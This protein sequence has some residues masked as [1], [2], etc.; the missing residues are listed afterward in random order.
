MALTAATKTD[1]YRFFAVAFNAAPGVT[2]MNQLAE[3]ANV[4]TVQQIVEVFTTKPEFT[5]TYPTFFTNS[6]FA[7]KLVNT[8]VGTSASDA[9]KAEAIADIEAALA[10][11]RPAA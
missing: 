1:L 3:A 7:T 5:A 6:Q 8:V 11:G 4:M 2:Y 9:A 10:A